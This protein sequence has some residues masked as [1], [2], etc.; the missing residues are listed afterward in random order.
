MDATFVDANVF[1]RFLTKDDPKK[2]VAAKR[3]FERALRGEV[4]LHTNELVIAEI[5]WTLESFYEIGR[6]EIHDHLQLLLQSDGLK[7][8]NGELLS[9]ALGFYR[10]LNVDFIDAYNAVWTRQQSIS[11]V[12]TYDRKHMKRFDFLQIEEP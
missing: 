5:V 10:D 1:L 6:K 3:L 7:V 11:R 4:L 12:I 9:E 2:A 8:S